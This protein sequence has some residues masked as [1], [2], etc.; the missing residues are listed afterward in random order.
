MMFL[1]I[2]QNSQKN[3]STGVSFLQIAGLVHNFIKKG[4][5]HSCFAMNFVKFL[6]I[7]WRL[8]MIL[9]TNKKVYL[10]MFFQYVKVYIFW[11]FTQYTIHWDNAN[12]KNVPSDK[13]YFTKN[14]VLLLIWNSYMNWSARSISFKVCVGFSIFDLVPFLFKF[15]F[16][17]KKKQGFSEFKMS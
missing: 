9:K 15:I 2:L 17:F 6:R 12:V 1:I 4:L 13:I 10:L 3:N 14:A 7:N 8:L 11:K 5:R 16:L